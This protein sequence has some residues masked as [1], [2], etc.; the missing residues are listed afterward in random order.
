[1]MD[2]NTRRKK[3]KID[4]CKNCG[5]EFN[6]YSYDTQEYCSKGCYFE[7][8]RNKR[9]IVFCIVCGKEVVKHE[10]LVKRNNNNYCN[11][12]CYNNRA[13]DGLKNIKRHTSHYSNLLDIASCECGENRKYLLEIHHIDG[14]NGNNNISNIE[15]LCSNC[16]MKRHLKLNKNGHWVYSPKSLTDRKLLSKL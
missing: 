16:H 13:K 5:K 10:S 11:R 8:V 2:T 4:K 14:N 15:I 12:E 6:H 7:S 3:N 1:M 9:P